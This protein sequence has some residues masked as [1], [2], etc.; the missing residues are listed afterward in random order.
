M[1]PKAANVAVYIKAIDAALLLQD[2]LPADTRFKVLIFAGNT[3]LPQQKA[4]LEK[5]AEDLAGEGE[6]GFLR[7]FGRGEGSGSDPV[8]IWDVRRG[9]VA[10]W[11]VS[12]SAIEGGVTGSFPLSCFLPCN[13][14]RGGAEDGC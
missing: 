14:Q 1:D 7:R 6:G 12:G 10:K 11:V 5:L 2:L 8:E 13:L 3:T 9:Y 4:R